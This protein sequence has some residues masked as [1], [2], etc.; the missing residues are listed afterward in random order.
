MSTQKFSLKLY[1]A[2]SLLNLAMMGLVGCGTLEVSAVEAKAVDPTPADAKA[3]EIESNEIGMEP[4]SDAV[5]LAPMDQLPSASGTSPMLSDDEAIRAAL[6]AFHGMN[7]SE[8]Y[9]FEVKQNT[10]FHARG[11]VDNGYFLAAKVDGQWV[12][13]DGGQKAP[14]C[15]EVARYGF[16][17]SL[18]PECELSPDQPADSDDAAIRAALAAHFGMDESE[19]YHFEVK[20]NS[21]S[22]AKG[23]VDNGYFL[24]AKVD[25][26]WNFVDGGHGAPDCEKVAGYGFPASMVPWCPTGGSNAPDCPGSGTTIAT[27]IADVTYPD[28]TIVSPGQNFSKTWRIKNVGTCTWNSDYLLVFDSGKAMNGPNAVQLTDVH[29]PPGETL[30]ISVALTAPETPGTYRGDWKFRD[31]HGNIFGLT[32]GN[33]I[34]VEIEVDD[35]DSQSSY[36]GYPSILIADVNEDQSVTIKGLNF[37]SNDTF[38]VLLNY[39]G[40]KGI[41]GEIVATV[42]TD[43]SGEFTATYTIPDFLHGQDSIAIRLESPSSDYYAYN[44]FYN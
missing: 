39:S 27:F 8:F 32:N 40:T 25:G 20:E 15:N 17:A 44:W 12:R 37:P 19:F 38:N 35:E 6:A 41:D 1:V 21:G 5:D 22:H 14:N 30:D 24:A 11:N 31:P 43:E 29:I 34:W 2:L 33:P 18:V 3:V 10:G 42:T 16:P 4:E 7:E 23:G 13:V 9:H 36:S 26:Q 28:G